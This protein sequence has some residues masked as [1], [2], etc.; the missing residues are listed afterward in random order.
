MFTKT[1]NSDPK[2]IVVTEN[3]EPA[4]EEK[5]KEVENSPKAEV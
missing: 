3:N 4:S 1:T 2:L 5:N